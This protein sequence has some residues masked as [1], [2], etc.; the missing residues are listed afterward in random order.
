M[1]PLIITL[2]LL[3]SRMYQARHDTQ[4]QRGVGHY[5]IKE[6]GKDVVEDLHNS[7]QKM[8]TRGAIPVWLV[9]SLY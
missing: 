2:T 7:L 3:R 9:S 5:L 1:V 8:R 6:H 4:Q